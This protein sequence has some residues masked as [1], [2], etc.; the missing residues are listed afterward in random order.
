MQLTNIGATIKSSI[1][2]NTTCIIAGNNAGWAKLEKAV[3]MN[4][5]V[6][7]RYDIKI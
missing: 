2:K 1:T 6:I 5:P 4:I 7:N 3:E